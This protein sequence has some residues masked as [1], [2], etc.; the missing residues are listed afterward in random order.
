MH[1]YYAEREDDLRPSASPYYRLH[2]RF[3]DQ[4][5][6][7]RKLSGNRRPPILNKS[8]AKCGTFERGGGGGDNFRGPFLPRSGLLPQSI[9][10]ALS[11]GRARPHARRQLAAPCERVVCPAAAAFRNRM[12]AIHNSKRTSLADLE[13]HQIGFL[14]RITAN[15]FEVRILD[16]Q[17]QSRTTT[18]QSRPGQRSGRASVLL[19]TSTLA[20]QSIA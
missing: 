1:L 11:A 20:L 2:A 12:F 17:S 16:R 4:Q 10:L 5:F 6:R 15:V 3:E 19:R 18:T 14:P 13:L 8:S 9:R 7:R